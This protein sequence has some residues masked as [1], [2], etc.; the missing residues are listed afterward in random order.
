MCSTCEWQ[1]VGADGYPLFN[2]T[3][4]EG[5]W[6]TFYF[7]VSFLKSIINKL[8]CPLSGGSGLLYF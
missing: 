1:N 7:L 2:L 6:R 4:G 5:E 8:S 3:V